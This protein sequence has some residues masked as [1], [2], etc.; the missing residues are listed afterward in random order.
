M[1]RIGKRKLN[2]DHIKSL[3]S[4][5]DGNYFKVL[6]RDDYECV[7]CG[8][9]IFPMVHHLDGNLKNNK[10]DNLLTV[11]RQCHAKLHGQNLKFNNPTVNLIKELRQQRKTYQEIADYLGISRQRVHQIINM[12]EKVGVRITRDKFGIFCV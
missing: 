6:R 8:D 5:V 1:I 12:A 7:L 10:I 11:C 2:R 9:T 3:E 4:R